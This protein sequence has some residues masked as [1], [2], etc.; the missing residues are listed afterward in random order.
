MS[1]TLD[2]SCP[3][4]KARLKVPAEVA[5][6]KIRC[7]QCQGVFVV[8]G[9][10]AAA[11]PAPKP[12][13]PPPPPPAAG[14]VAANIGFATDDDNTPMQV[15]KED[16]TPRCPH[17]T[18]ELDPPDAVVCVHCGFNNRTRVKAESKKVWEASG[19]DWAGHLAPGVMSVLL[20]IG[21][22]VLD[23]VCIM[24]MESWMIGSFLD[25]EELGPGGGPTFWVKPGAFSTFITIGSL[26][27][28]VP[29]IRFAYKRLVKEYVPPEE[30]KK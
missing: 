27:G 30:E 10:P 8:S 11:A 18:K 16:D 25:K 21:L 14:G 5:G 22:V 28:I 3:S 9:A 15:I 13:A 6:K 26:A 29:G 24:K 4:C 17:C 12:T 7:K 20:V 23:I 19:S 1:A 2:V